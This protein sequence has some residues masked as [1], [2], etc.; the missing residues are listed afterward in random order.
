MVE[1]DIWY[2]SALRLCNLDCVYCASKTD[3]DALAWPT[4][5]GPEVN[6][7]I[8]EAVASLPNHVR[9]RC[10]TAGEPFVSRPYLESIA[11]TTRQPNI[12][13]VEILTNGSFRERQFR[14]FADACEIEKLSLWMTFHV[15]QIEQERFLDAA[16]L[17]RDCGAFVVV[18]GVLFPENVAT[19]ESMADEARRRGLQVDF[20]AGHNYNGSHAGSSVPLMD[21]AP[22]QVAAMYRNAPALDAMLT[23]HG[24]LKGMPCSAGHDYFY[25]SP[26][27]DVYPC[28]RYEAN[29]PATR[30]GNLL[31]HGFTLRRR[32]REYMPCAMDTGCFCKEDYFHLKS[33]REG[34][35]LSHRSMGYP[36]NE[37][38][39]EA[40]DAVLAM[41]VAQ[42]EADAAIFDPQLFEKFLSDR[43]E[44]ASEGSAR[45]FRVEVRQNADIVY[46][47]VLSS[48]PAGKLQ[49]DRG[50][51][52]SSANT[53]CRFTFDI[54]SAR[55]VY[56]GR[57]S[58]R[59]AF[60]SGKLIVA[61][62]TDASR[63]LQ[64]VLDGGDLSSPFVGSSGRLVKI[65]RSV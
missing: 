4:P 41:H 5:D 48:G 19:Y 42:D 3:R 36:L 20:T 50:P 23:A 64:S 47:C 60:V 65:G 46:A 18:H 62:D 34:L 12:R 25:I 17:A 28:Y 24:K 52:A 49:V 26:V 54:G 53:D 15:G 57:L 9:L 63:Y 13:S 22:A 56:G 51:L 55:Q 11:W 45:T 32:S 16:Q 6:R 61:G 37:D 38:S 39:S 27:G 33:A 58:A 43:V 1:L 44:A 21:V 35:E 59:A 30:L 8:L 29:F 40:R 10:V 2:H 7:K 31:E 14:Q